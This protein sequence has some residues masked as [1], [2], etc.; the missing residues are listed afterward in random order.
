VSGLREQVAFAISHGN[1]SQSVREETSADL[2][3]ALAMANPLGAALWRVTGNL[4]AAALRRAHSILSRELGGDEVEFRKIAM[5]ALRE[6]MLRLCP[7]CNGR[8][9]VV[10]DKGV[11]SGCMACHSTGR[12]K[13]TEAARREALGMPPAAYDRLA[14]LLDKA[15][16]LLTAADRMVTVEVYQQLERKIPIVKEKKKQP[17]AVV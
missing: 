2:I 8:G 17:P 1:L 11:R 5:L 13:Y 6:W 10:N 4:D 15:H 16:A 9:C 12:G 7:E 14:P 3:G